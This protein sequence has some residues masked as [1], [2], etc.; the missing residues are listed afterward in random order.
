M[1]SK[2]IA[3]LIT[4]RFVFMAIDLAAQ[5]FEPITSSFT[6]LGRSYV[7][8]GDFDNDG[9]LD[10]AICGITTAGDHLTQIYMNG[11]GTFIDIQAGIKGVKDGSLEW[12]DYDNDGDLD[13]LITGNWTVSLYENIDGSFSLV[14]QD[15]GHLQNSRAA[16]G[17]ST[18]SDIHS[19]LI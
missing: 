12:G 1:E 7:A 6:G 16:W 14:E 11:E 10:V 18:T 17:D 15:F 2:K 8:W 5:P 4:G 13:V 9:D 19:V 3:I